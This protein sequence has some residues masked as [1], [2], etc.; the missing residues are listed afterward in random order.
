M[1]NMF[2]IFIIKLENIKYPHFFVGHD[3]AFGL[4][5]DLNTIMIFDE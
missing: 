2:V 3:E 1:K 5:L 4:R